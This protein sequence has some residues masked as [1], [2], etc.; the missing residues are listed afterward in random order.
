MILSDGS[1]K[2]HV[3]SYGNCL[4]I[5]PFIEEN[6][7]A[8]SID[9]TLN[10]DGFAYLDSKS[11]IIDPFDKDTYD[12]LKF[13][14]S[15]VVIR[16][17]EF[18][19]GSVNEKVELPTNIAA[20][21]CGKSSLARL[22]IFVHIVAGFGDPGWDGVYVLEFFNAAH[23]PV[24]LHANMKIAQVVFFMLDDE[25]EVPYDKQKNSKYQ[26]QEAGTGSKYYLNK[27]KENG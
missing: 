18:L 25:A 22:G 6:L 24:I 14:A 3:K 27:G 2:N 7:N 16:P 4:K 1:I 26:N 17:Y 9:F 13:S 21:L 5:I 20:Q 23:K 8:A 19:L 15:R 10:P 12:Y 11:D